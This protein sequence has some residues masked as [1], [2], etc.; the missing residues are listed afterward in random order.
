M[1]KMTEDYNSYLSRVHQLVENRGCLPPAWECFVTSQGLN[2]KFAEDGEFRP[3]YGDTT[4]FYLPEEVRESLGC[5][6]ESLYAA[7]GFMLSQKLPVETFHITLHDL[8]ASEIQEETVG[9]C[10]Y[11]RSEM[12]RLLPELRSSGRIHLRAAGLVSMVSSSVV[13]LF[14]P[15][16]REDH[17]LIREMYS[18]IDALSPLSYPLTLHCTLAYYKPGVYGPEQW[19]PLEQF[20]L[21]MNGGS[22]SGIEFELDSAALEYQLFF[23][24]K[25]YRGIHG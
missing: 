11:H 10:E 5:V 8:C 3:F 22:V 2:R 19:N 18:C 15:A 23:S 21:E 13:M 6:Q 17:D 20:I 9:P 16:G 24:M 12:N 25:D 7:A 1:S 4:L 14:E